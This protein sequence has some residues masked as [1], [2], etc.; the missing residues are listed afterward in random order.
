M[1]SFEKV[2]VTGQGA[3]T[4]P[5]PPPRPSSSTEPAVPAPKAKDN[6]QEHKIKK[7]KAPK[8]QARSDS[9]LNECVCVVQYN[10]EWILLQG[11]DLETTIMD[12]KN[13]AE[14]VR[15]WVQAATQA[16]GKATTMKGEWLDLTVR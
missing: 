7:A 14:F 5:P 6:P 15:H 9:L 1:E 10:H 11:A 3:P 16:E 4:G 2:N 8:P 12:D 13:V